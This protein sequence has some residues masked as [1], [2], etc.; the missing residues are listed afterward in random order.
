MLNSIIAVTGLAG[1]AFMSWQYEDGSM[2]LRDGL[3]SELPRARVHIY[4]YDSTLQ[5]SISTAPLEH[6]TDEFVDLLA[7][8]IGEGQLVR[9]LHRPA[10]T[11]LRLC[12]RRPLILIGHSLGCLIIKKVNCR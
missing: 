6:F 9:T 3:P 5:E 10:T 7:I 12:Q 1:K 2:W 4:G 8:Y 11:S